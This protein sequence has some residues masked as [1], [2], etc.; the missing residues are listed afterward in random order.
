MNNIMLKHLQQSACALAVL[1]ATTLPA[2]AES[3]DVR[4]IGTITPTACTPTLS[5]GGTIDYGAINPNT[6]SA[7]AYTTLPAKQLDFAITCDAPAKVAVKAINGRPGTIAGRPTEGTGGANWLP[8]GATVFGATGAGALVVG[9][10][11]AGTTPVGGYAAR[12]AGGSV[13]ADGV[14]VDSI[15]NDSGSATGGAWAAAGTAANSGAL[16]GGNL[17]HVSWAASGTTTPLAFTTL[18]GKLEVQAYLN[19]SSLLDLTK[20]VA[21]DGLTTIE[22]VY[23]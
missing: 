19:Y 11:L 21:L 3:V 22:L 10:G 7:T 13:S 6:L 18:A 9:L 5:G 17:R 2:M 8:P 4:V 1:A 20:P 12:I 14:N 16:Y 15:Y 23:L